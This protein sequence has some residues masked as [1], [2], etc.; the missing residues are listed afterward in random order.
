MPTAIDPLR[1]ELRVL[2]T[3]QAPEQVSFDPLTG[4]W[5]P[6]SAAFRPQSDGSI[7]VDLEEAQVRDGLPLIHGYP[8]VGRAVGL[9]AHTVARMKAAPYTV[10]H[11]IVPENDYHGEARG[12]PSSSV[13]AKLAAQ[14]EIIIPLDGDAARRHQD[15]KLARAALKAKSA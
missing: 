12:K 10:T 13:R 5:V 4:Q 7:S 2:R 6:T 3:L 14:C 9:V 11:E 15:E 1:D 8:R